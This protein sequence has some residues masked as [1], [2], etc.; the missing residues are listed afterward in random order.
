MCIR[1]RLIVCVDNEPA[2]VAK[3]WTLE[4]CFEELLEKGCDPYC[5]STK[6]DRPV[7]YEYTKRKNKIRSLKI[8]EKFI[9]PEK[10][11]KEIKEQNEGG[12]PEGL[13][14]DR[15]MS[16]DS[17]EIRGSAG[18]EEE[19][20]ESC[21]E[22]IFTYAFELLAAFDLI[23]DIMMVKG[24]LGSE[25]TAWV[26]LTIFTMISPFFVCYVPLINF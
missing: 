8:L 16:S 7:L 22:F 25:H 20:G 10:D 15:I 24:L 14:M 1:D 9:D 23:G 4:Y 11:E 21:L 13:S 2:D 6:E 17:R 5:R 18:D 12:Q 3:V 26:V 19:A